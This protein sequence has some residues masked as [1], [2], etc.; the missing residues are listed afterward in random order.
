MGKRKV[1]FGKMIS[2]RLPE[3]VAE[4][5]TEKAKESKMSLTDFIRS[6]VKIDGV[7]PLVPRLKTQGPRVKYSKADPELIRQVAWIGNNLNQIAKAI[8]QQGII[9]RELELL[10]MLQTIKDEVQKVVNAD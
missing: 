7:E 6:Q 9:K 3:N 2:F 10:Q 5:W 4:A 8:N 1:N